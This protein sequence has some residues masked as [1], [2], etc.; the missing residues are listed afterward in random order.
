MTP[1]IQTELNRKASGAIQTLLQR[2]GNG[3]I[4]DDQMFVGIQ[5]IWDSVS[6]LVDGDVSDLLSSLLSNRDGIGTEATHIF[7]GN[8]RLICLLCR[9]MIDGSGEVEIRM[10]GTSSAKIEK[11]ATEVGAAGAM[12]A[13]GRCGQLCEQFTREG[14]QKLL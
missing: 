12:K 14:Y 6:G 11:F 13:I 2:N 10:L 4:D 9:R 1:D 8:G 3:L 5:A 7:S